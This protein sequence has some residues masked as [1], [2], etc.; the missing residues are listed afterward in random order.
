[1]N[2]DWSSALRAESAAQDAFLGLL[3]QDPNQAH[4]E[5]KQVRQRLVEERLLFGDKPVPMIFP[6][7]VLSSKRWEELTQQLDRL[8]SVLARIE[9]KLQE[10][11]WL[12]W[13]GFDEAEQAWIKIENQIRPGN[14]ISRVD[15]FLSELPE[16]AGQYQI[17]E[18]NIDSPGGAAFLDVGSEIVCDTEIWKEFQR[19]APGRTIPFREALY[20]HIERVWQTYLED[21]PE[22]SSAVGRPRIAIVD[23]VTVSTHREFE[24]IAQGLSERGYDTLVADP[25]ELSFSLGRLRCYDGKPIDL[26][27]R[28][29]L[30]EDMLRDPAGSRAVI[31]ACKAG[32]V[33]LVNSFA[34]KPLTVKSLLAL[35]HE[36]DAEEILST[37]DLAEIKALVPLTLKLTK[38]NLDQVIKEQER[39]V[40]KPADGWGAQGL[41]LGWRCTREEWAEHAKRSLALG[42]YVAQDR[43]PIPKRSLPTWT[44]AE[45]ECFS[46]LFDL[47]PY[48][49]AEKSVSPLVRL[50]PS[51]VLNVKRGAQIAAVWVL[52]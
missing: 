1:M 14:T 42:G 20:D 12:D 10:K 2:S 41:Y 24:L 31:E 5:Y 30:V 49:L 52:D 9:P 3:N 18:L 40:L 4:C 35:F 23:W 17:V 21:N 27:Y 6:P 22:A 11:K 47:S 26:V 39:F 15:G 32:A 19:V 25:R 45:W 28:R 34:S 43:V 16:T 38:K 33:C 51:E 50:S 46:Y 37:E 13:L 48:G 29:V 36:P 8:N 44:G 7:F